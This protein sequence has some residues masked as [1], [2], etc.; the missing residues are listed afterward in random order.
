[1]SIEISETNTP[2]INDE[3]IQFIDDN[4]RL[5][6][7][8]Y[9][10]R[11]IRVMDKFGYNGYSLDLY[12]FVNISEIN[13][14]PDEAKLLFINLVVTHIVKVIEGAGLIITDDLVNEDYS[15]YL[16]FFVPLL[17]TFWMVKNMTNIDAIYFSDFI[18][19]ENYT[20]LEVIYLIISYYNNEIQEDLFYKLVDDFKASFLNI[21]KSKINDYITESVDESE[22]DIN[23]E[24]IMELKT[25]SEAIFNKSKK[26]MFGSLLISVG[27]DLKYLFKNIDFV[28]LNVHTNSERFLKVFDVSTPDNYYAFLEDDDDLYTILLD[29]MMFT[30]VYDINFLKS[31]NFIDSA[32]DQVKNFIY[33]KNVKGVSGIMKNLNRVT[34][35]IKDIFNNETFKLNFVNFLKGERDA[36]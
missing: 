12:N 13:F 2:I 22:I 36:E 35:D 19:N 24:D 31:D 28:K 27:S 17:E 4:F 11:A 29:I 7:R 23:I 8:D 3:L 30:I 33:E 21:I 1:M 26:S 25:L 16:Y 14:D 32:F 6:G 5:Y 9:I 10:V 18:N 34:E 20:N 15:E